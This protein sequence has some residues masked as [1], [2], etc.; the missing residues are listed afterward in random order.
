[1]KMFESLTSFFKATQIKRDESD[2]Q[3]LTKVLS[4][5]KPLKNHNFTVKIR[6]S[7]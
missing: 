6:V 1:M 3:S 5:Q 2:I 7:N 4:H